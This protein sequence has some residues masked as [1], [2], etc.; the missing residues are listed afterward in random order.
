MIHWFSRI[1]LFSA[2]GALAF[3]NTSC[4]VE[5]PED[6]TDSIDDPVAE[7]Q[8]AFGEAACGNNSAFWDVSNVS[9]TWTSPFSSA[10]ATSPNGGYDHSPTCPHQFSMQVNPPGVTDTARFGVS[11]ADAALNATDCVNSHLAVTG[12]ILEAGVTTV[13]GTR[14][15]SGH[16]GTGGSC[17]FTQDGGGVALQGTVHCVHNTFPPIDICGEPV[18][19]GRLRFQVTVASARRSTRSPGR[20]STSATGAETVSPW[21]GSMRPPLRSMA[22]RATRLAE[23]RNVRDEGSHTS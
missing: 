10:N 20:S 5:G 17:N 16:V 23:A 11:W 18:A 8:Q 12:Y 7:A 13:V 2:V 19:A 4:S 21:A 6:D 3:G 9:F 14:T 15:F 1:A 22:S